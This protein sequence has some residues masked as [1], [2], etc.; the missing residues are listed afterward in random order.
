MN[1]YK[2][3]SLALLAL[4][5]PLALA[6]GGAPE[7]DEQ[8]ALGEAGAPFGSVEEAF[9]TKG[10]TNLNRVL[11]INENF[12]PKHSQAVDNISGSV[13][14]I[15]ALKTLRICPTS[16]SAADKAS[17]TTVISQLNGHTFVFQLLASPCS[18]NVNV[19]NA[20]VAGPADANLENYSTF[21]WVG[22][23]TNLTTN[24][25]GTFRSNSNAQLVIDDTKLASLGGT[26]QVQ[27]NRRRQV[28][29][30]Q[31]EKAAGLGATG[32]GSGSTHPFSCAGFA[33]G[34]TNRFLMSPQICLMTAYTAGGSSYNED[35]GG[36][37]CGA[38]SL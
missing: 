20:A 14:T 8:A 4:F 5:M 1:L 17:L 2:K 29:G 21:A 19:S 9:T 24:M 13:N 33:D 35:T 30:Y 32:C 28:I 27:E 22:S 38:W 3:L 6:C 10:S 23:F 34:E 31:L 25:I 26:A 37:K 15:P 36:T 11:G 16:L 12:A 7:D 18:G